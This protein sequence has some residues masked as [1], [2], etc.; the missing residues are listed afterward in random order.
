MQFDEA[1]GDGQAKA[2][3]FVWPCQAVTDLAKLFQ[4]DG[5]VVGSYPDPRIGDSNHEAT[6]L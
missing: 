1:L 6:G 5:N 2:G 3:P 4:R